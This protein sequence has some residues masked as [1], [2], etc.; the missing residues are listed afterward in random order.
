MPKSTLK[1]RVSGRI[2][3]G[4][5]SGPCKFLSDE[6]EVELVNFICGCAAVGYAK[7]K[8]QI[9]CLVRNVV[10]NKGIEGAVTTDG[11][12]TSFKRRHGQLTVQ[13]GEQ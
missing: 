3:F 1:D 9:L 7:S 8:Q 5:K 11:W 10:E 6:E 13:A 4:K 12:W 2:P